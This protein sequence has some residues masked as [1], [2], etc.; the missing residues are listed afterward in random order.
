MVFCNTGF[1]S[2]LCSFIPYDFS[3]VLTYSVAVTYN[4]AP[5]VTFN[6]HFQ[7]AITSPCDGVTL[8]AFTG[9]APSTSI[10][11]ST[12]NDL[13]SILSTVTSSASV[14][15]PIVYTVTDATSGNAYGYATLTGNSLSLDKTVINAPIAG[16]T[17]SGVKLTA[18][19]RWYPTVSVSATTSF[20]IT[21]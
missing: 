20:A 6:G 18:F 1:A 16:A 10:S 15:G 8:S 9:V 13:T 5:V 4:S 21:A 2:P 19:L 11:L 3:D 7:V 14:C 12:A 17:V